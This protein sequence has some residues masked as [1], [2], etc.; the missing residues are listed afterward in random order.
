MSHSMTTELEEAQQAYREA[1]HD[2]A[3]AELAPHAARAGHVRRATP[4]QLARCAQHGGRRCDARRIPE[5]E[6]GAA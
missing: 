5:P 1:A 2:F 6:R 4:R 3:Q